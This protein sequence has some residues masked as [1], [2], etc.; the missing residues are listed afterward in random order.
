MPSDAHGIRTAE[1]IKYATNAFLATQVSFANELAS[2][3]D[4]FGALDVDK[5][6]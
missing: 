5:V 4:A 2:M 3:C 1:M 6:V